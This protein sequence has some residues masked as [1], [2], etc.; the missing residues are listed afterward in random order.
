M[1]SNNGNRYFAFFILCLLFSPAAAATQTTDSLLS[2]IERNNSTL[3]ALRLDTDAEKLANRTETYL[4]NPE[5]GLAYLWGNPSAIG[6]RQDYSIS[7]PLDIATLSGSRS[8]L[9]D[10]KDDAAEWKYLSERKAILTEARRLIVDA[11][12]YNAVLAEQRRRA[13]I[14]DRLVTAQRRSL[15]AGN[16]NKLDY[17]NLRLSASTL[18]ADIMQTEAERDAVL[19]DLT[20]LNGG[21]AVTITTTTYDDDDLPPSFDE[22]YAVASQT[23]PVLASMRS[24][25][26]VS[27]QQLTVTQQQNMPS[28]SVGYMGEKTAG[29]LY[30]GISLG[31]S[32]PLWGNRSR[33]RQARA[34]IA[35]AEQRDA[36]AR[37]Q[38]YSTLQIQ[39]QRTVALRH[40]A[41]AL[42][43]ALSESDNTLLLQKSLA[44]GE[45]S[46]I[47][48][49][50]QLSQYYDAIDKYLAAEHEY[51]AMSR[52]WR[53][54]ES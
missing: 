10:R 44:A 38:Y 6:R 27:R 14:A 32:V 24:A 20:R 2:V 51:H 50:L 48:Y 21:N 12:Y 4:A 39:Y 1:H 28:L 7:Q 41:D 54:V 30:H 16:S 52:L 49:L 53:E 5:V 47:D 35:A 18:H 45:I 40:T 29:E 31:I 37:Q 19:A 25:I 36:D 33:V 26:D 3:A 46:V 34:A 23:D 8:R 15:D 13:D 43:Q 9:A 11:I 22:W 42:R 17:N